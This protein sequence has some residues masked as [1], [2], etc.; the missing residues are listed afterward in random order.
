[1]EEVEQKDECSATNLLD[2]FILLQKV[3]QPRILKNTNTKVLKT[4]NLH[5]IQNLELRLQL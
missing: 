2:D 4:Q 5:Q 3:T 1:M